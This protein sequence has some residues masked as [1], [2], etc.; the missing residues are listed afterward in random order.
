[1]DVLQAD[2][3]NHLISNII[4]NQHKLQNKY[5]EKQREEVIK[6]H[7][8]IS[9]SKPDEKEVD[10]FIEKMVKHDLTIFKRK[11]TK[12]LNM[13]KILKNR[14]E[15]Q[16]T[17]EQ[18]KGIRQYGKE[19][20]REF[21]DMD[22]KYRSDPEW[23][24]IKSKAKLEFDE[25]IKPL[26]EPEVKTERIYV[27]PTSPVPTIK[28]GDMEPTSPAPTI[29][30]GDLVNEDELRDIEKLKD[31]INS[32]PKNIEDP[33]QISKLINKLGNFESKYVQIPNDI[34]E[35]LH[36]HFGKEESE[37]LTGYGKRSLYKEDKGMS[38]FEIEKVMRNYPEFIG[39]I[40]HNEIEA[41]ILPKVH[42]GKTGCFIINTDPVSKHGS[43]WQCSFWNDEEMSFYDSYGDLPDPTIFRGLSK[44]AQKIDKGNHLKFK[45]NRIRH[46]GN[47]NNCGWFCCKYLIDRLRGQKFKDA[48][49]FDHHGE[50][51]IKEFKHDFG[52]LPSFGR[53]DEPEDYELAYG[54]GFG[55]IIKKGWDWVKKTFFFPKQKLA[56]PIQANYDKIK[57]R[58]I[59]SI[60][61]G[62][63]PIAKAVDGLLNILSSG[64]FQKGKQ[65][66]NYDKFFHLFM[67][68]H[69]DNNETW[70]L[71]KNERIN[72]SRFS[73][74]PGNELKVVPNVPPKMTVE[75][76]FSN[77][78][79]NMGEFKF[80]MYNAL[81]NNCQ[82]F[83]MGLLRGNNLVTPEVEKFVK[84]PIGELVERMPKF[85]GKIS[86]FAT[87]LAAKAKEFLGWGKHHAMAR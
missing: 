70:V 35:Q 57:D 24:N 15:S 13:I 44:I 33:E 9:I 32:T 69:L 37:A 29:K 8:K 58:T 34:K 46:Q 59:N 83:I 39:C 49:G 63:K 65:A 74:D 51:K 30:A 64:E 25:A 28:A 55:D 12:N 14:P 22:D 3:R 36:E 73:P 62:R 48:T 71:E 16:L 21:D 81:E 60:T 20:N 5:E 42:K 27:E 26:P 41:K 4:T 6:K 75:Q 80:F 53:M 72:I 79:K 68:L 50:G 31:V 82:D 7:K 76:L 43:H 54:K 86:Q 56:P 47:S 1:M 61:V 17:R 40:C 66:L 23:E 10:D 87:D 52:F 19:I 77:G 84:Q 67:L 11:F 18:K 2:L 45:I 78:L 38:N 85:V